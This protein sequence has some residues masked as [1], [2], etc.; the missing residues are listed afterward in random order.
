VTGTS[1]GAPLAKYVTKPTYL[2]LDVI[3]GAGDFAH[4][5]EDHS[6]VTLPMAASL[7][8]CAV[9]L[10]DALARELPR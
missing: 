4:H 2:L 3:K 6:V 8:L 9:E 10:L 1:E 5:R 7:C